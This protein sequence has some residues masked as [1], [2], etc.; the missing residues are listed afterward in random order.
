MGGWVGG[1]GEW[2]ILG[3]AETLSA[4][5][6]PSQVL[7]SCPKPLPPRPGPMAVELSVRKAG[8]QDGLL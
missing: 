4:R 5:L 8:H 2:H 7:H 1:G 6:V 3:S